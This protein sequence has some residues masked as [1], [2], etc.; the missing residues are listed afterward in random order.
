M[1]AGSSPA[2]A[3]CNVTAARRTAITWPERPAP[4][5]GQACQPPRLSMADVG[6]A[7]RSAQ[8]AWKSATTRQAVSR[9]MAPAEASAVAARATR[10][11]CDPGPGEHRRPAQLGLSQQPQVRLGLLRTACRHARLHRAPRSQQISPM[12][13]RVRP[14]SGAAPRR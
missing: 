12:L 7:V 1:L 8:A 14:A 13:S 4:P 6:P 3:G 11:G 2:A 5:V 10:C 9:P